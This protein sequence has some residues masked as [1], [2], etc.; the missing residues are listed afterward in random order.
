VGAGGEVLRSWAVASARQVNRFFGEVPGTVFSAL[1]DQRARPTTPGRRLVFS[2]AR[3]ERGAIQDIHLSQEFTKSLCPWPQEA[4]TETHPGRD[5]AEPEKCFL[6]HRIGAATPLTL[7]T[8]TAA[9]RRLLGLSRSPVAI[10]ARFGVGYLLTF[11]V[12][13]P[14]SC[15]TPEARRVVDGVRRGVAR[16]ASSAPLGKKRGSRKEHAFYS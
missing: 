2:P 8:V 7:V 4:D 12:R 14:S 15:R 16:S 5:R 9:P 6:L 13:L 3:T 10:T 11:S 1:F